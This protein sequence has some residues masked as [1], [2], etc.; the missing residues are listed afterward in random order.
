MQKSEKCILVL[1]CI[2]SFNVVS[3]YAQDAEAKW[4]IGNYQR[5]YSEARSVKSPEKEDFIKEFRRKLYERGCCLDQTNGKYLLDNL[6][7]LLQENGKFSDLD[8]SQIGPGNSGNQ[9]NSGGVVTESYFRIRYISTFFRNKKLTVEENKDTW[10]KILKAIVHYGNLEISR[11]NVKSRFHASCFAIPQAAAGIYFALLPQMDLAEHSNVENTLLVEACDMLKTIGLQAWTQP[12]RNDETDRNVVQVERFRKHVWWVGGN[13]LGGSAGYRPLFEV[14]FMLRSIPMIDLLVDICQKSISVT[15]QNT[16]EESFW[17]EGLTA[18]GAGWGHGRQCL[19]WGYPIDGTSGA[20]SVLGALK[21]SPWKATLSRENIKVLMNYFCGGNYYYYK[22]YITPCLDR[23]SMVYASSTRVIPYYRLLQAL[24]SDWKE[25]FTLE[26]LQEL[27][28]LSR[29]VETCNIRMNEFEAYNGTRWFFNN[30]DL[31]KKNED[32]YVIVNMSSNRCDGMESA[33]EFADAYNF[34]TTDGMT[35]FQR[36]GNEY[37]SI[38]GGF[39]VTAM[40]GVTAREGM[41]RLAPVT[42]WRGYTSKHNF[43]AASTFGGKNAVAGYIFEKLDASKRKEMN[44]RKKCMGENAVLYGVKAYKSYFILG[45]YMVALGA[46]ITNLEPEQPENIRTTIEQTAWVDS[47]YTYRT[48]GID[49]VVQ[50]NKFAYSVLPQ[51]KKHTHHVCEQKDADW[52]KMNKS[53]QSIKNCPRTINVFRMW[54]DHGQKPVN[55]TYGYVVYTGNGKPVGKYPFQVVRNDTL[56]QCVQ[57]KDEKVTEA[58]FYHP[59]TLKV[60]KTKISVS[61]PCTL[62]LEQE[63]GNCYKFSITDAEMNRNLQEIC[64][65]INDRKIP[66]SMPQGELCGKPA[67]GSIVIDKE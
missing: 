49:W 38:F 67:V 28:Q 22:G 51:Y 3:L 9:A 66:I 54:I 20:L 52:V 30:D 4:A 39:D 8:D 53:N 56:V 24:L 23:S 10:T 18:D 21:N 46:G 11:P 57:S 19:I 63:L 14:A 32:C 27:E 33:I 62:L 40:P 42:N 43:A 31:I 61:A 41:G 44:D 36:N 64:L 35:M 7:S 60:G 6:V 1:L 5:Y 50:K 17:N 58:V 48:N 26:E 37:R 34:Y 15:S 65:S 16:Y 55:D 47:I 59:E 12:V 29:E 25:L 13:G 45:D 2:L